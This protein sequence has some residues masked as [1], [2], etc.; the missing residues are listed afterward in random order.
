MLCY[1]LVCY[2]LLQY[3]MLC[4]IMVYYSLLCC[5]I[6][7]QTTPPDMIW[8]HVC[9]NGASEFYILAHWVFFLFAPP[10]T[11]NNWLSHSS[12]CVCS[13]SCSAEP[14]TTTMRLPVRPPAEQRWDVALSGLPHCS[15]TNPPP[16]GSAQEK[17]S[18]VLAK[19]RVFKPSPL[20]CRAAMCWTSGAESELRVEN[21]RSFRGFSLMWV[22][23]SCE[24]HTSAYRPAKRFWKGKKKKKTM[25]RG[26][27]LDGSFY[28]SRGRIRNMEGGA[29]VVFGGRGGHCAE[30]N[31]DFSWGK[32]SC[33][34]WW[35]GGG[36]LSPH[37]AA[38]RSQPFH[39]SPAV[40]LV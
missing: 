37:S 32:A 4:Y 38:I 33:V 13:S 39:K 35:I 26:E 6:L 20:T 30:M 21:P 17:Q 1:P 2:P 24:W 27:F 10:F 7:Y 31:G 29:G 9:F 15:Q 16:P 28:L 3:R 18:G 22:R 14:K 12:H 11:G 19:V 25:R 23:R 5:V 8:L 34:W 40:P 36:L